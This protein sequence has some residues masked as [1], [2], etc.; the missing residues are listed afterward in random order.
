[1]WLFAVLFL[2]WTMLR[3]GGPTDAERA[4]TL[5]AELAATKAKLAA[6]EGRNRVAVGKDSKL[7][8]DVTG[9]HNRAAWRIIDDA[10]TPDR[11]VRHFCLKHDRQPRG[12]QQ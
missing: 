8:C 2:F 10:C 1:M 5:E 3:P 4:K 12:C 6:A 7:F 11:I 9:C